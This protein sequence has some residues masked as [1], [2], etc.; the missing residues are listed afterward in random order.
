MAKR[1]RWTPEEDAWILNKFA[2]TPGITIKAVSEAFVAAHGESRPLAGAA[3]RAS[4]LLAATRKEKE[5]KTT[6]AVA[7]HMTPVDAVA[8]IYRVLDGFEPDTK[9]KIL[10]SVAALG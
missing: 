7:E 3:T 8:A 1:P 9:T 5:P 4:H 10:A 6:E 2:E